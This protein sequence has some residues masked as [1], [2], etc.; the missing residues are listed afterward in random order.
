MR[1]LTHSTWPWLL[2]LLL[3]FTQQQGLRHGLAHALGTTE[4]ALATSVAAPT[5]RQAAA[6]QPHAVQGRNGDAGGTPDT[7][8]TLC[9][10]LAALGLGL[11]PA[12]LHWR[13]TRQAATA[14]TTLL[15]AGVPCRPAAAYAARAPPCILH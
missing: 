13:V 7:A 8:C 15:L 12:A 11:V 1:R 6:T 10:A 14:A 5:Q 3:L 9:L 2:A 4:A